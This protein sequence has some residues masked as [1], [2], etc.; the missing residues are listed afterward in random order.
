MQSLSKIFV[1]PPVEEHVHIIVMPPPSLSTF[2]EVHQDETED[3]ITA[4]RISKFS[5]PRS[6]S[7]FPDAVQGVRKL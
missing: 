7:I 5:P 1:Q 4:L 2:K 3:I 6:N